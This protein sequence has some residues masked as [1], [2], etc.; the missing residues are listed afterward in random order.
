MGIVDEDV[1]RVREGADLADVVSQY[2]TLR[3]VGRRFQGLCPFHAEKTPSFS[4]NGEQGLYYC[5]GC[6]AKGDVITFVREIEHLDFVG[7]VEWLAAR[8][9][10]SL[11]YTNRDESAG[12]ARRKR[13]V[14]VMAQAVDWYHQRLRTGP[15]AGPARAYLRSRGFDADLVA[16]YRIGWAPDAWDE[17]VSHLRVPDD[18][19]KD[20]GLGFRNRR[21]RQQDAFRGRVLFPIFDVSGDPVGFGG[22]ILP[23]AEGPKYKN[24]E[25]SDLYD[26]SRV[27]YGLSWVKAE[28]VAADEVVVCEGYTDVIGFAQAGV[29]RAVATCGTALT[30]QHV[31]VLRRFARRV[32]LA[33]DADAAGQ[34]A[35]ER[36]YEWERRFEID[37]AVAD[38]PGGV[39][40]ADL[41]RTDPEALRAAVD[42]AVPFLR[43]RLERV[44]D[45]GDHRTAEGRARVA[46]RALAVIAEHPNDLVRD[47]YVMEVADR[48]HLDA[49]RLRAG[50][51]GARRGERRASSPSPRRAAAPS[52]SGRRR[53]SPAIEALRLMI[54]RRDEMDPW[55]DPA[56]FDD[57]LQAA[58]LVALRAADGDVRAAVDGADPDVAE[59]LSR[60]AVDDTDAEPLD[61]AVRL[62]QEATNRALTELEADARRSDDPLAYVEAITWLKQRAE[63]LREPATAR[64]SAEQLLA[65]LAQRSP[66]EP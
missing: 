15:D 25:A 8:Q 48:L 1:A 26:K 33:F 17:L 52:R 32:V 39:D 11:R 46:E 54:Q 44:L 28:V 18:V 31:G 60:L 3:R 47:Q 10:V 36:F 22:R 65:W 16:R 13:L 57:E 35:A 53:E 12:R 49:D 55:L 6:Q 4:V 23:G 14:E 56:L 30:E 41:A 2:V 62:A 27:L 58:A 40:P 64:E 66:G 34:A 59:L 38:L 50:V 61:V 42:G 37:V 19:L 45:A 24:S 29:P 51:D 63:D 5:F 9:G 21:G 7:A 43:F 20:T